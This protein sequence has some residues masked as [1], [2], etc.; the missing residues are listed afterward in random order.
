VSR[1]KATAEF[2]LVC[3]SLAVRME[4]AFGK[5]TSL[6][7]VRVI[8]AGL[9]EDWRF[10]FYDRKYR[11]PSDPGSYVEVARR[12]DDFWYMRANH[13]W[14]E[15]WQKLS[16]EEMAEFAHRC[17]AHKDPTMPRSVRLVYVRKDRPL[18]AE[19]RGRKRRQPRVLPTEFF[20]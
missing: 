7:K 3:Q 13:G 14:H 16:L 8:L 9:P 15:P 20:D 18:T 6:D 10:N 1:S 11:S 2:A 5:S 4:L 12:G 17:R 19:E